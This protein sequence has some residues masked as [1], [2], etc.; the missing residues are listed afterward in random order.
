MMIWVGF[1]L[2][3][4]I[5]AYVTWYSKKEGWLSELIAII[6]L[7][8][9]SRQTFAFGFWYFD[10]MFPLE[11]ILYLIMIGILYQSPKQMMRVVGLSMLIF[12]LTAQINIFWGFL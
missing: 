9:L 6:I 2:V 8:F 12:L 10:L 4:P 11:L 3:S 5:L 7:V 1:S